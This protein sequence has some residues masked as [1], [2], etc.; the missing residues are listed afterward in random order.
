MEYLGSSQNIGE[1]AIK[2]PLSTARDGP[3]LIERIRS[4]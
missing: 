3:R 2:V 1:D 4:L